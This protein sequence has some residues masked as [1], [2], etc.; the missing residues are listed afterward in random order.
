[1][2]SVA[3]KHLIISYC[4]Q[5]GQLKDVFLMEMGKIR[6]K[7]SEDNIVKWAEINNALK[8]DPH[9]SIPE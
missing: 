7:V 1:M 2:Y 6:E 9:V 4:M 8:K 3:I 5:V